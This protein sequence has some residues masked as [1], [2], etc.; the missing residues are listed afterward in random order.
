MPSTTKDA[1]SSPRFV[2]QQ[3][4]LPAIAAVTAYTSCCGSHAASPSPATH[5]HTLQKPTQHDRTSPA[6]QPNCRQ[7]YQASPTFHIT[8]ARN[9]SAAFPVVG[10]CQA[11]AQCLR[12]STDS[13]H[14]SQRDCP[15]CC[16]LSSKGPSSKTMGLSPLEHVAHHTPT[17]LKRLLQGRQGTQQ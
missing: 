16:C 2:Q 3:A 14:T 7:V 5:A 9:G 15:R 10:L 6:S 1:A 11:K 8:H 12:P 4:G 17:S 13:G